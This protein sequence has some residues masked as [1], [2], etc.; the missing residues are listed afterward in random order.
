MNSEEQPSLQP[1]RIYASCC[2]FDGYQIGLLKQ[3]ALEARSRP[4]EGA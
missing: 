4:E 2:G 1:Q 3:V